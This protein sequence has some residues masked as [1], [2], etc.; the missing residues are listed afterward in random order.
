MHDK[1]D[2]NE[3]EEVLL[4]EEII[5]DESELEDAGLEAKSAQK[6]KKL[7]NKLAETEEEKKQ[8]HEDL[9]RA[10]ADFLNSKRRL[11]EQSTQDKERAADKIL[12]ELLTLADSFD[13]A[14]ADEENWNS[15]EEKWRTGV[16]AIHSKL[17]SILTQN[18][19][20]AVDPTGEEFDPE[21]HEAVSSIKVENEKDIDK[22]VTVMQT[23]YKKNETI[24]RPARVIVG[25]K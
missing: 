24:I 14:K 8:F 21:Q 16:D 15:V 22:I 11:E 5:E 3:T 7:R 9:Q 13:T 19:I 23:G 18:N 10:R 12:L 20:T 2:T 6:I 1:D 17:L 4:D 25:A